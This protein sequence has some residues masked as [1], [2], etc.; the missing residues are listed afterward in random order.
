VVRDDPETRTS[1]NRK[2][3]QVASNGKTGIS[4]AAVSNILNRGRLALHHHGSKNNHGVWAGTPSPV[5]FQNISIKIK[6]L[7]IIIV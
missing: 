6:E 7:K 1:V 5:P 2:T 4:G 3:V